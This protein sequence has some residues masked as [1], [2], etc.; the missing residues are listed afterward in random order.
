MRLSGKALNRTEPL[1]VPQCRPGDQ[2]AFQK[3][4]RAGAACRRRVCVPRST[5]ENEGA[6][7]A[8]DPRSAPLERCLYPAILRIGM[9]QR[10]TGLSRS[11]I[12][13]LMADDPSFPIPLRLGPRT[14]GWFAAA[15]EA[16]GSRRG[17]RPDGP[18][19]TAMLSVFANDANVLAE[20]NGG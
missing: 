3:K 14:M 10:G 12:Y 18:G 4:L 6:R 16:D 9:V 8:P 15:V 5:R 7:Y 2:A 1:N 19:R 13:R 17:R 20:I 11:S